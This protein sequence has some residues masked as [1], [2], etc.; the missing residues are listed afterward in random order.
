MP[1]T[2]KEGAGAVGS[3]AAADVDG[4]RTACPGPRDPRPRPSCCLWSYQTIFTGSSWGWAQHPPLFPGMKETEAEGRVLRSL[5]T[6]R[7]R[8]RRLG[9]SAMTSRTFQDL[10]G[11]G[12]FSVHILFHHKE[13]WPS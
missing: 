13:R 11:L 3:R 7:P 10:P 6:K 12:Q 1:R 5:P 9:P 2:P 8:P 4:P